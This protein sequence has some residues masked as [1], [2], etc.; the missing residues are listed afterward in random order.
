VSTEFVST[1][2]GVRLAVH[3]SGAGT[4]TPLVA[5]PGGPGLSSRFLGDLAGV[6]RERPLLL[7]DPR[8][9]GRSSRPADA[10][11]YRL[12]DH[13]GD[14]EAVRRHLRGGPVDVLGWSHG[15]IVALLHALAHPGGVRRLVV[16]DAPARLGPPQLAAMQAG[17]ER[18]QGERWFSD[19]Y[20]ALTSTAPATDGELGTRFLRQLPLYVA[21]WGERERAFADELR[22]EAMNGDSF[23][24]F[25]RETLPTLDLRP[26]LAEVGTPALV[27]AGEDDFVCG[28]AAADDL[29]AHLPNVRLALI[30]GAGHLPFVEQPAAFRA[31]V[32][33]FLADGG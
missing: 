15:G 21:R 8:G 17:L 33:P 31:A 24:L 20:G 18:R 13:V 22:G 23:G 28:P 30:D 32:A 19:A 5:Y 10:R 16:V 12:E 27:V 7:V 11:A 9:C 14:L 2:D 1:P 26:R 6:G 25:T 3:R 4:G 29:V